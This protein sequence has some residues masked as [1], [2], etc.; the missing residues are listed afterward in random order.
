MV[1]QDV[2]DRSGYDISTISRVSNSKYIQT[3]YATIAVKD[4]FTSGIQT[5]QGMVSNTAVM[6]CLKDI[7]EDEDKNNPYSD[8]ALAVQLANKGY[9]VARRT[10]SKYREILKYPSAKERKSI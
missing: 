3:D 8:E 1:L 9:K 6:E 7:I 5:E 10:V 4:L 2:A